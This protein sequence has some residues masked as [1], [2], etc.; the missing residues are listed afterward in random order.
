MIRHYQSFQKSVGNYACYLLCLID[1]A[2][3]YTHK[4]FNIQAVI[5]DA[6]SKNYV[7]FNFDNYDDINNFYVENPCAILSMLTGKRWNVAKLLE[8]PIYTDNKYI[9]EWYSVN[10]VTGHFVRNQTKFNSLQNSVT[11]KHGVIK[12]WR[13]F[14]V[15]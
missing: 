7:R 3:Q 15:V 13:V 12:S 10:G 14:E 2:E 4:S 11:V 5:E 6:I 8:K 9:V 1:I